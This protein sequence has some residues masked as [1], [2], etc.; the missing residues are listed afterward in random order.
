M[1][2][3]YFALTFIWEDDDLKVMS[4]TF[5]HQSFAQFGSHGNTA[6]QVAERIVLLDDYL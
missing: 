2:T 6:K 3:G 5:D 4:H 1:S